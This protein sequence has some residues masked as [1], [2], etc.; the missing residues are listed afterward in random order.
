MT[1]N[2]MLTGLE[3][4]VLLALRHGEP[5]TDTEIAEEIDASVDTVTAARRSLTHRCLI[6]EDLDFIGR[7]PQPQ[8]LLTPEGHYL[9]RIRPVK[10]K[11]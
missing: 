8:W 6:T 1:R 2:V 10:G 4:D 9:V 5:R 3:R 11:G 7:H